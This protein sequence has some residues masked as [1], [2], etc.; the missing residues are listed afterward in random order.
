MAK[1]KIDFNFQVNN[2]QQLYYPLDK[3]TGQVSLTNREPEEIRL[4]KFDAIL[5]EG[6]YQVD[7]NRSGLTTKFWDWKTKTHGKLLFC[8]GRTLAPNETIE[9]EFEMHM[10][11]KW[12]PKIKKRKYKGWQF[13][14]GFYHKT[15]MKSRKAGSFL[16]PVEFGRQA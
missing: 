6:W 8:K 2:P 16:I 5:L 12:K 13:N 11:K 7:K 9:F 10:P 14:I 4:K 3:I 15:R 1:K